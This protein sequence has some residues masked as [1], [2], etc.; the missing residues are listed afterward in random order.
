MPFVKLDCGMLNSTLWFE[1]AAR[2]VFITALLMA[3]PY[4]LK[5]PKEQIT[6]ESLEHTGWTIPPGWYG[7][8]AAAGLGIISR[9]MVERQEGL[10]ALK[11][12][13]SPEQSSR[14]EDFEGR[15]LVRI[16]GG[17]LVLNYMKY[18]ER[19]YSAA[20]RQRRFRAARRNGDLKQASRRDVTS[21]VTESV[22]VTR[23][24]GESDVIVTDSR[25]QS[26]ERSRSGAR[27]APPLSSTSSTE[28][29]VPGSPGSSS[30]Q[31]DLSS[32]DSGTEVQALTK[33]SPGDA[34]FER[35]WA[36]YPRRVSKQDARK[37]WDKLHPS[38]VMTS[39]I[40]AAV[41]AQKLWPEWRKDGGTFVPYPASWLRAGGWDNEPTAPASRPDIFE[42]HSPR[43]AGNAEASRRFIERLTG[44]KGE[45]DK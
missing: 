30:S 24:N 29:E 18:R 37:A 28:G 13:A 16:D 42:T 26:T 40:I 1:K 33:I 35:F 22:T 23:N 7:F 25:V 9:A 8:V 4:E 10:A 3:E 11:L 2:D 6:T 27:V 19:D 5:E 34:R 15:R 17:Y 39:T 45:D 38:E 43:T 14:S 32:D 31:A 12:L 36:A 41:E 21:R 44:K 20:E